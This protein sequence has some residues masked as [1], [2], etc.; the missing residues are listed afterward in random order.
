[1]QFPDIDPFIIGQ[2]PAFHLFGLTIGPL[3]VRWYALAY[4]MGIILGWR[5]ALKLVRGESLW[6]PSKPPATS[7]QIDDLILW[8][9]LGIIGGGRLG[10]ALFY[11]PD[12]FRDPVSILK[13]WDGGMSFHGGLIGVVAAILLFARANKMDWPRILS[14][15]DIIAACAPIGLFFGRIAN[16]INGELWGRPTDLPWGMVFCND[17][18]RATYGDCP[19][20]GF[21]RHPSQLYEAALEGVFLFFFLR[22]A[23]HI[24]RKLPYPGWVTGAFLIGYGVI[25]MLLETVREPDAQMPP[26]LRGMITMGMLLSVPMALIGGWLILRAR[27]NGPRPA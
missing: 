15:G 11:S 23:T 9:T 10:Y 6:E 12:M 4:V 1:M 5:Y 2:I 18:I 19:A 24:A 13:L 21:A 22:W 3:G 26:E 7:L 20:G 17:T 27:K 25:R 8:L 16:F 14:L